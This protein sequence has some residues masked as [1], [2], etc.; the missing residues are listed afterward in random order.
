MARRIIN[1]VGLD[2]GVSGGRRE[3]G[4]W[5]YR[6]EGVF[7]KDLI[8]WEEGSSPSGCGEEVELVLGSL[9]LVLARP[10]DTVYTYTMM[11]PK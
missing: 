6:G 7:E 10:T 3:K 4:Y 8:L 11:A 1:D 9:A 2:V 5:A